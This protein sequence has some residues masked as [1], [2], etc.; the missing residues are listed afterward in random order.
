MHAIFS[1][2]IV[3]GVWL[4]VHQ[5]DGVNAPRD[6]EGISL[7]RS[8]ACVVLHSKRCLSKSFWGS[9]TEKSSLHFCI[10]IMANVSNTMTGRSCGEVTCI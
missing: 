8:L 3:C 1:P 9:N 5:Q 7:F 6:I 10:A 4:K 2:V